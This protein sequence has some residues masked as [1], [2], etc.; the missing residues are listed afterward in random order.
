MNNKNNS[1]KHD[2]VLGVHC[3]VANCTY[4]DSN[5]KCFADNIVVG[6]TSAKQR[7]E[8]ICATFKQQ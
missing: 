2:Q 4:N 1:V 7:E 6:P 3:D 8:T 5:C